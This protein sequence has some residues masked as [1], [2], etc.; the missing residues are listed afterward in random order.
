[1]SGRFL[2]LLLLLAALATAA[3]Y[4]YTTETKETLSDPGLADLDWLA[5][6]LGWPWGYY[7]EVTEL[8]KVS[9]DHVAVF[10]YG[11]LRLQMLG[12][13]YLTWLVVALLLTSALVVF[14][15]PRRR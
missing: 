10:E 1:M 4:L 13:T 5:T 12:Q 6:V 11:D 14:T 7:A 8:T 15:D 2:L 9:E 3:T